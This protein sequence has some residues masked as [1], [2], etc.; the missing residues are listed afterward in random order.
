MPALVAQA[1]AEGLYERLFEPRTMPV[2]EVIGMHVLT[3]D[4]RVLGRIREVL[5]DRNTGKVESIA[6]DG[7]GATYPVSALLSSDAPGTV[8]VEPLLDFS[9]GGASA[10]LVAPREPLSSAKGPGLVIDLQAGRVRREK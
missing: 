10:L 3:P 5:F 6:V 9:S 8:I 2:E 1:H 4:G 7:A